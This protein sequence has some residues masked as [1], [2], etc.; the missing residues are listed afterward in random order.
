LKIIDY[1]CGMKKLILTL[2]LSLLTIIS[3]S[4]VWA[5]AV[6]LTIGVRD[7]NYSKF[8]WG[9]TK[10]L[11][12][13]I[14]IKFDDQE[15]TIYTEDIQFYQTL[16]PEYLTEDGNGSYW[17]AVDEER[18]RCK[19]YMYYKGGNVIMIEYDDVCIIYGVL[20]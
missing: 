10:S 14:L 7:D 12:G 5:K 6:S 19:L 18:K 1:I 8:T 20:Y 9:E 3:F 15:V 16:K 4:Q 13:D 11:S 17:F 2:V